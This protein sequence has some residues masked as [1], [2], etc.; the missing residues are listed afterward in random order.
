MPSRKI[1]AQFQ[2]DTLQEFLDLA[3]K[4]QMK[5]EIANN[6]VTRLFEK[7]IQEQK[8]KHFLRQR[9]SLLALDGRDSVEK[10]NL[11]Q[12]HSY[13]EII[14]H[15]KN[16]EKRDSNL[17]VR[18]IQFGSTEENR[19]LYSLTISKKETN[20]HNVISVFKFYYLN[21]LIFCFFFE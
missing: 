11:D 6:N 4:N 20:K 5:V 16:L 8:I 19:P 1:L 7:N 9:I 12:Y 21:D 15:L 10:F 17:S 13:D 18:L 3:D 14:E 2:H